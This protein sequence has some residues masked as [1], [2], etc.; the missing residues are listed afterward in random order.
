MKWRR[1]CRS[2]LERTKREEV[3][4]TLE[5]TK[6]WIC[7][8]PQE[9]SSHTVRAKTEEF[10]FRKPHIS[11]RIESNF[12]FAQVTRSTFFLASNGKQTGQRPTIYKTLYV[13]VR[14]VMHSLDNLCNMTFGF[15]KRNINNLFSQ[16]S[17]D[18]A[19]PS[20]LHPADANNSF[21]LKF[22]K[23]QTLLWM[24]RRK[25][26]QITLEETYDL[27]SGSGYVVYNVTNVK[28]VTYCDW[29][30]KGLI[31]K[32]ILELSHST[33]NDKPRT[34]CEMDLDW[35]PWICCHDFP[36]CRKLNHLWLSRLF[37]QELLDKPLSMH[38]R[39]LV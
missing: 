30:W 17:Q 7:H 3:W 20:S 24:M 26:P 25:V 33:L 4:K 28:Y 31:E 12:F 27:D 38:Q 1:F 13:L 10:L 35:L 21:L 15:D 11:M 19:F 16:K 36:K 6:S 37:F 14:Y 18:Q 2:S 8:V 22:K 23:S 5:K 34:P 9:F 29:L 39:H 32:K